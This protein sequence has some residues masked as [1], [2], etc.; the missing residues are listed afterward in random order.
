MIIPK[1][2]QDA[3]VVGIK[4]DIRQDN[5]A[6]N[7]RSIIKSKA[8]LKRLIYWVL[9]EANPVIWQNPLLNLCVFNNSTIN[10]MGNPDTMNMNAQFFILK[11]QE[12]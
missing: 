5:I 4:S 8:L 6:N 3:S 1:S 12:Y 11:Q 2:P 9:I 7:S 10:V